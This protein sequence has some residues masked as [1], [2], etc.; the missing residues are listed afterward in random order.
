MSASTGGVLNGDEGC[1]KREMLMV[2]Y[3]LIKVRGTGAD[4]ILQP[5]KLGAG[6]LALLLGPILPRLLVPGRQRSKQN[7]TLLA[8]RQEEAGLQLSFWWKTFVCHVTA[9]ECRW[10]FLIADLDWCIS[11]T[12]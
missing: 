5:G 1:S 10:L 7:I 12:K 11:C 4:V 3:M 2:S 9:C 8:I 6:F